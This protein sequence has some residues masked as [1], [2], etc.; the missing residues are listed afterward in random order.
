MNLTLSSAVAESASDHSAATV[1]VAQALNKRRKVC[2]I[3]MLTLLC[4]DVVVSVRR[5]QGGD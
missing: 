4:D 2:E 1:N 5:R 3:F